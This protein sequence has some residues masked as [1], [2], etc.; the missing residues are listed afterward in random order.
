MNPSVSLRFLLDSRRRT[1][2]S[3]YVPD[4]GQGDV[5]GGK[6][7]QRVQV[8]PVPEVATMAPVVESTSTRFGR[9]R[10]KYYSIADAAEILGVTTKS[11]QRW[12]ADGT[13]PA[14][15]LGSKVVRISEE[16]LNA[17]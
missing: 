3:E 2:T 6:A 10:L 11:V 13:I 12:I 4:A 16:S 5:P 15:R 8:I 7:P 1:R 17:A 9:N 14:Y